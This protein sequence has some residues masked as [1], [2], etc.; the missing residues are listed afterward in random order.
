MIAERNPVM[1]YF[2][3]K[4]QIHLLAF[5]IASFLIFL[6]LQTVIFLT[7]NSLFY[8]ISAIIIALYFLIDLNNYLLLF[9]KKGKEKVYEEKN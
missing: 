5:K 3:R 8:L 2:L 7:H 1:R 9:K 4:G 6:F